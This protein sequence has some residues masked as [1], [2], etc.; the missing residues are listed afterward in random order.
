MTIIKAG[1]VHFLLTLVCYFL[2]EGAV[3][4]TFTGIAVSSPISNV[5]VPI[6]E[7]LMQPV[8]WF[9]SFDQVLQDRG[10]GRRR[11]LSFMILN[12]AVW[13]VVIAAILRGVEHVKDRNYAG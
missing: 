10:R 9:D 8:S 4:L 1:A 12:S 2:I 3:G 6:W 7:F 5:V 11:I 13:G